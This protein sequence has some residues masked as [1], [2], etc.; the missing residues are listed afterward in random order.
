[1]VDVVPGYGWC[2]QHSKLWQGLCEV[3]H[4]GSRMIGQYLEDYTYFRRPGGTTRFGKGKGPGAEARLRACGS[5]V[6]G[7]GR[8]DNTW[9]LL[10]REVGGLTYT[11]R[12]ETYIVTEE[13][14]DLMFSN[15]G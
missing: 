1:M 9:S 15:V 5:T 4:T 11:R 12:G 2:T 6:D 14:F 8:A 10:Y 3:E 13:P 7:S